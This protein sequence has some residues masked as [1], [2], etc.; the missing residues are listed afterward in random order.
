MLVA[1]VESRTLNGIRVPLDEYVRKVKLKSVA[2]GDTVRLLIDFGYRCFQEHSIRLS[3]VA[4][5]NLHR[6]TEE[7]KQR[8]RECRQFVVKWFERHKTM[9]GTTAKWPFI[10]VSEKSDSFGRFLGVVYCMQNHVLNKDI[11]TS[12]LAEPYQKKY[13]E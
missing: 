6:G 1:D 4:A 3:G 5:N 2:D 12:G 7:E 9:C 10:L 11:L 8:A 13:N